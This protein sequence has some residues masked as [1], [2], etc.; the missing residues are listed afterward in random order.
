MKIIVFGGIPKKT[1]EMKMEDIRGT[2]ELYSYYIRNEFKKRGVETEF[3]QFGPGGSNAERLEKIKVPE[4]DHALSF[5]Q[6]GFDV[7][8]KTS[9][10]FINNVRQK[11]KGKIT[12]ICD[13]AVENPI[14]DII[15]HAAPWHKNFIKN[16]YVNW[17]CDH[18]ILYPEKDS[19]IFRILIDHSYYAKGNNKDLTEIITKQCIEFQKI[20]KE[21]LVIIR[22][23]SGI[24]GIEDINDS[25]ILCGIYD[26]STS[27][28]YPKACEEYRKADIFIVTHP[29]SMGLS[30]LESGAAGALVVTP[31]KY[32]KCSLLKPIYHISFIGN[33]LWDKIVNMINVKKSV[34]YA[35]PYKW[36][37]I[38]QLMLEEF[39]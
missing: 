26:R 2:G 16:K 30:V 3:C 7:R 18:N 21:K 36:E 39:K 27:I 17:A 11:I 38:A 12:S 5:S 29:E 22:R 15:F 1:E 10:K 6:R 23:F 33:I 20:Y 34:K 24:T 4:G 25:N 14:E 8:G 35:S 9:S 28:P 13:H 31:D 37:N 19:K 32:I